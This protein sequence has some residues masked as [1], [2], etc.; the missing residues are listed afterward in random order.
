MQK[1]LIVLMAALMSFVHVGCTTTGEGGGLTQI[2][3]MSEGQFQTVTSIVNLGTKLGIGQ[4]LSRGVIEGDGREI[5]ETVATALKEVAEQPASESV[6]TV[7][8]DALGRIEALQNY[9]N[10]A[11]ILTAVQFAENYILKRGGFG[12]VQEANGEFSL[13]DRSKALVLAVA[14]GIEAALLANPISSIEG[15]PN[16][17]NGVGTFT[18]PGIMIQS[19]HR[20]RYQTLVGDA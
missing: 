4:L 9:A 16:I 17:G 13:S 15:T 20:A 11:T 7:L 3:D 8:S 18:V 1:F 6:A 14:D 10:R 19:F 2:E 12:V 5:L